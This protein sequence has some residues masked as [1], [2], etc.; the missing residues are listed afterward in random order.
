MEQRAPRLASAGKIIGTL[1]I[2]ASVVNLKLDLLEK[3]GFLLKNTS[4]LL[5]AF[6]VL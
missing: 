6:C 4:E 1:L 3:S 2:I 5:R